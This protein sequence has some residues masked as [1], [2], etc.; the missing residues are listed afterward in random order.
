VD[1]VNITI[2]GATAPT[3]EGIRKHLLLDV[4]EA[5]VR[6]LIELR[7]AAGAR[8]PLITVHMIV[9]PE[10]R[11]EMTQF[12]EKWNGVADHVGFGGLVSR[13]GSVPI[14]GLD[15]AHWRDTPCFLLWSQMPILSDG[16]VAMCCD[17]WDGTARLGN[18]R[19]QSIKSIWKSGEQVRLRGIHL[20]G[21]AET[22]SHCQACR[23]PRSGPWWFARRA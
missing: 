17:D 7:D 1:V 22:I 6:R 14:V 2:D 8:V 15:D 13:G 4:V 9:M 16:S 18:V 23:Q 21:K 12:L 19:N 10:N 3:Y 5:N 11:H 20:A